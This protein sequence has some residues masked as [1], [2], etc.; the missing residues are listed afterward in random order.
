MNCLCCGYCCINYDV[1][2]VDD[3]SKGI[4]E[5]NLKHKRGGERC[6][7]LK[8]DKV[9]EYSCAVHNEEWYLETPCAE[10]TQIGRENADCRIG[11]GVLDGEI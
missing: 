4:V 2:I 3:P 8:G 9:G 6:Q 5:S 7:H 10:F 1:I 11:R